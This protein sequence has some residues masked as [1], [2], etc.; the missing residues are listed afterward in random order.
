MPG[1]ATRPSWTSAVA[2]RSSWSCCR[3]EGLRGILF[4]LP[5]AA[6]GAAER[7]DAAGLADRCQIVVVAPPNHPGGKAMDLLLAAVGG[8]ARTTAEWRAL[9]ADGGFELTGVR[10]GPNAS[11]LDAA[12]R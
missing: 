7:L 11:I 12:P 9:L 3:A 8:R 5:E 1:M 10:P 6:R 2:A 4:D